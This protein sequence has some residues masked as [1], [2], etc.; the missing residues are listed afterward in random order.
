MRS[1]LAKTT[2]PCAQLGRPLLRVAPPPSRGATT[3]ARSFPRVRDE[4]QRR[5]ETGVVPAAGVGDTAHETHE[6]RAATALRAAK[7]LAKTVETVAK[8]EETVPHM[9]ELKELARLHLEASERMEQSQ[10][11]AH[12]QMLGALAKIA[13]SSAETALVVQGM[14]QSQAAMMAATEKLVSA[15]EASGHSNAQLKEL[16]QLTRM[17][18]EAAGGVREGLADIMA[19]V[20]KAFHRTH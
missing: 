2:R 3:L 8:T 12:D 11:A 19:A 7:S 14:Q 4:D 16:K 13:A 6:T 1:L 17:Q 20:E 9:E 10:A 5:V 18:L 15:T